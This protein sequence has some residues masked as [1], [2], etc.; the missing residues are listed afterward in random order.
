[1]S[2]VF[3]LSIPASL[4]KLGLEP[5]SMVN[6]DHI[7]TIESKWDFQFP[8]GLR[9]TYALGNGGKLG[10]YPAECMSLEAAMNEANLHPMQY[11]HF[12]LWPFLMPNDY[13]S[14]TVC[15]IVKGPGTGYVLQRM[16]DG[17]DRMLAPSIES[18][19]E[20]LATNPPSD[21][22]FGEPDEGNLFFP[23]SLTDED[24]AIVTALI[25]S[26]P[27]TEDS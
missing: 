8:S 9:E 3:M 20:R 14:D 17:T 10:G 22:F 23:R 21:D 26:A 18:F 11:S 1:M 16:H 12:Y 27:L 7:A 25:A 13:A 5:R 15:V 24:H 2:L 4:Q 6:Q 19:F